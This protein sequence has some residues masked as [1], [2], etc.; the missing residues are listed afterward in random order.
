MLTIHR[1]FA[2]VSPGIEAL[3]SEE[4][5]Q[6]GITNRAVPGGVNFHGPIETLWSCALR[7]R[8]AESIRLRLKPFEAATFEA[9]EA[10]LSRLPWHAYLEPNPVFDVSVTCSESRLYHTGAVEERLRRVIDAR[11]QKRA[12]APRN[13]V[14]PH[15]QKLMVRIFR[16]E[17]QVSVDATGERLHR[18]GYRTHVGFAPLRETL[19]AA[20]LQ[21]LRLRLSD[22]TFQRLWDPCCGSGTFLCEWL[23]QV[24]AI[25]PGFATHVGRAYAFE[26]WPVHSSPAY[27]DFK[28]KLETARSAPSNLDE[29]LA[30]GSD[31]DAKAIE[32]ARHNLELAQVMSRATLHAA[33][34]TDIL[35]KIPFDTAVVANLPYGVRLKRT[36]GH[37][38]TW[39]L[40]DHVLFQRTDLRPVLLLTTERPSQNLKNA[41]KNV[42]QFANGGLRVNAWGLPRLTPR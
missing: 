38:S 8:L 10:G 32:A 17:V 7:S 26:H 31:R 14:A 24:S 42:A 11:E 22:G 13:E 4:L 37:P 25:D 30:F 9:L 33:N 35:E 39:T 21:L 36:Q 29:Y 23:Q 40:L 1:Y 27:A 15:R 19:A 3:L 6:L 12:L 28:S 16:N 20:T 2:A 5:G 41:W 34:F 18:R